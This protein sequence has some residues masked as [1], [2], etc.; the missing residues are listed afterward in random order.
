MS[1][2]GNDKTFNQTLLDGGYH[3]VN[4]PRG[5]RKFIRSD[6]TYY[7]VGKTHDKWT[8]VTSGGQMKIGI[9]IRDLPENL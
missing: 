5:L 6:G 7:L 9:G 1:L 3:L 4:G 8:R 2:F